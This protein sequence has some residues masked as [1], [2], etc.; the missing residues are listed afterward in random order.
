VYVTHECRCPQRS[1]VGTGSP[2]S[3]IPGS[4]RL[5]DVG[6]E[7]WMLAT[8]ISL[9]NVLTFISMKLHLFQYAGA[10]TLWLNLS[11]AYF[12]SYE[13]S[14]YYNSYWPRDGQLL[15]ATYSLFLLSN[16]YHEK[17]KMGLDQSWTR[18]SKGISN[19]SLPLLS[20]SVCSPSWHW[21][22]MTVLLPQPSKCC[23]FKFELPYLTKY[24]CSF[25]FFVCFCFFE[26]GFLC[27]VLAVL[28]LTL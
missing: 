10:L 9:I 12:C 17:P 28:E 24:F 26:I 16:Y 5:P 2:G 18:T 3:G 4:Y 23:I 15:S 6:A 1:E 20:L 19:I 7:N 22:F 8:S 13:F 27:V 21:T 14:F 25:I 11:L